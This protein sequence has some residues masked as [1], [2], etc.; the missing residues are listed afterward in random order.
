MLPDKIT[1]VEFGALELDRQS[2]AYIG[3]AC[4]CGTEAKLILSC[5]NAAELERALEASALLFQ[6]SSQWNS[7]IRELAVDELLPVKNG[8]WLEDDETELS[9]EEFLARML[10]E[11]I[12]VDESGVF[13]FSHDDDDMFWGHK[14]IVVG[15]LKTGL[16][17]AE[18]AG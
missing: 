8:N 17:L 16:R 4:W 9:R 1:T 14:I 3:K 13:V 6:Q 7:R 15:D 11:Y 2:E 12:Q 5:S 10:L 18:I